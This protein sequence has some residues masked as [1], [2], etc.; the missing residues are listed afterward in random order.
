MRK[1]SQVQ[2]N[3]DMG[4]LTDGEPDDEMEEDV[5]EDTGDEGMEEVVLVENDTGRDI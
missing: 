5:E 1:R 3:E 4:A 2:L